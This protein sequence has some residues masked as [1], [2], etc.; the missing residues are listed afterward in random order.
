MPSKGVSTPFLSL[1]SELQNAL[2]A[3]DHFSSL[4][5]KDK[6]S[7]RV[8]E[9]TLDNIKY[10]T[11]DVVPLDLVHVEKTPVFVQIKYILNIDTMWVLCCK[12]LVPMSFD[13]SSRVSR[14]SR[15]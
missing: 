4:E 3:N 14:K 10:A 2:K 11:G 8:S 6:V 1:P 15:P 13:S 9:L 5:L 12:M 7:Q